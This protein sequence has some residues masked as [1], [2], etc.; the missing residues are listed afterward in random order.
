MVSLGIGTDAVSVFWLESLVSGV[1]GGAGERGGRGG[2]GGVLAEGGCGACQLLFF[3]VFEVHV[4]ELFLDPLEVCHVLFLLAGLFSLL[5]HLF[6]LDLLEELCL[7]LHLARASPLAV[8]VFVKGAR[9]RVLGCAHGLGTEFGAERGGEV[10]RGLCLHFEE[11][12]V[13]VF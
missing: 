12:G 5:G 13:L 6:E 10:G 2:G 1:G 3:L 11:G 8:C 7:G 4:V 9:D